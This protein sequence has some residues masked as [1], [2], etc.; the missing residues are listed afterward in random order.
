MSANEQ[1]PLKIDVDSFLSTIESA[2]DFLGKKY[3][4]EVSVSI[5][6]LK[7]LHSLP[8]ESVYRNM[9]Q[10]RAFVNPKNQD[11]ILHKITY[12]NK[13]NKRI[14]EIV[15]SR[16]VYNNISFF[17]FC[18]VLGI[19]IKRIQETGETPSYT[20]YSDSFDL[21]VLVEDFNTE[22]ISKD[23][24]EGSIKELCN[25]LMSIEPVI[26]GSSWPVLQDLKDIQLKKRGYSS[27]GQHGISFIDGIKEA[28]ESLLKD[29][30]K[31]EYDETQLPPYEDNR[32]TPGIAYYNEQK[33]EI[34][35]ISFDFKGQEFIARING[36]KL[37]SGLATKENYLTLKN[38]IL[39]T[40]SN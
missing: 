38:K 36:Q 13:E 33:N 37:Y 24:E 3:K 25:M 2:F 6:S 17:T 10:R 30:Y 12:T 1:L 27:I 26:N 20:D 34:I 11:I 39:N 28:L 22:S 14:I 9:E 16:T 15:T 35:Y 40:A 18:D 7:R 5:D 21:K 19:Y 23:Y 32:L 4:F 31:I 8:N 29:G